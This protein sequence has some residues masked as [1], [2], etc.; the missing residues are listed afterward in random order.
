MAIDILDL[1]LRFFNGAVM[2]RQL[3]GPFR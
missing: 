3:R 1:E 2:Q